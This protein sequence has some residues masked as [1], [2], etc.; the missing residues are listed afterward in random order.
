MALKNAVLNL[1]AKVLI[2]FGTYPEGFK[3]K[4]I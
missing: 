1:F 4:I 3:L 2:I